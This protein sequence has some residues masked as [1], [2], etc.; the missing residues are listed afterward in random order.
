MKKIILLTLIAGILLVGCT[1]K[2]KPVGEKALK[3][4]SLSEE[5]VTIES[6]LRDVQKYN[7]KTVVVKGRVTPG[8]AF[9]F[10]NEQPYRLDDG[11]AQIW[12]I[13]RGVMPPKDASITVK[14]EVVTPY[15]IKGRRFEVAIIE[16]ERK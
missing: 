14:G 2:E 15:Q 9:E 3:G 8:L 16:K 6:I 1:E 12:V 11:T 5:T 10:V 7:G 4:D 13:T